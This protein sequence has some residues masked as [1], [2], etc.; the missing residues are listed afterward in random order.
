MSL[1][2]SSDIAAQQD[3]GARWDAWKREYGE[4]SR[5]QTL[6]AQVAFA[7][8]LTVAAAWLGLKIM[9]IPV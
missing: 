5:Q 6:Y 7:I 8:I 2:P 9:T 3:E 4:S 1:S